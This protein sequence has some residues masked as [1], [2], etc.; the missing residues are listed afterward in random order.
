MTTEPCPACPGTI[1]PAPAHP[2]DIAHWDPDGR[3]GI[4]PADATWRNDDPALWEHPRA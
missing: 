4:C 1:D 3:P 2:A